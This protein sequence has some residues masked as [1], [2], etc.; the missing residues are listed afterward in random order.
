LAKTFLKKV[1]T[2]KKR[3]VIVGSIQEIPEGS[4]NRGKE[5]DKPI[6]ESQRNGL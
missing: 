2:N 4:Q 1:L 5:N 3:L 6:L